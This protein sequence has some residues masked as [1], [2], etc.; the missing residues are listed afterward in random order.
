[1]LLF[2]ELTTQKPTFKRLV[3]ITEQQTDRFAETF[4]EQ[5]IQFVGRHFL[6][7]NSN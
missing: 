3:Y 5:V 4:E 7:K 6:M 2:Y 1:M